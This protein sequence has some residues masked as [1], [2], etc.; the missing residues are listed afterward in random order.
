MDNT[1]VSGVVENSEVEESPKLSMTQEELDELIGREKLKERD[2]LRREMEARQGNAQQAQAK[3]ATA[4]PVD[5]AGGM[6][7]DID[8]DQ[9]NQL[10]NARIQETLLERQ[11]EA[12]QAE[13]A[14]EADRVADSFYAKLEKGKE[15]YPD[16]EEVI[17]DFDPAEF[18]QLIHAVHGFDNM[19]DIMVELANDP[20]KLEKINSW[21][22]NMPER[23]IR[24]LKKLSDSIRETNTAVDEYQP[25]N[26]PLSQT[27]PSNVSAGSGLSKL[28]QL[29]QS[30]RFRF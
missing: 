6:G 19:A 17:A 18:P 24:E 14:A 22:R 30:G 20:R 10:V 2:K 11:K 26:A 15:K 28:E 23:G 7:G 3:Q 1:D 9:I 5:N 8:T 12:E 16:F 21:L 13:R 29:K 25:T 27:K 4:K